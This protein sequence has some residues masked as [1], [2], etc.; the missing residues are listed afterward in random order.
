MVIN[1]ANLRAAQV[2]F[3]ALFL[4]TLTAQTNVHE[5]LAMVVQS[6]SPEETYSWLK[7][8]PRL[9]EWVGPRVIH[10]LE[11][12]GFTIRK[13]DWEATI[14]V[15]RDEVQFDK[16]NLVRPRIMELARSGAAHYIELLVELLAGG[17]ATSCWDGQ[18]FFDTDH[19]VGGVGNYPVRSV[20]NKGTAALAPDA[21]GAALAAVMQFTDDA[22]KPLAIRPTHLVH[23]PVNASMAKRILTAELIEGESNIHRGTTEALLLPELGSSTAWF[24]MDLSRPLKPLILQIVKGVELVAQDQ[25]NDE[26]VF[27]RKEFRYGVDCQDN[28]GYG[29]WQL[30]YGSTGAGS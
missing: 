19:P 15:T 1:A 11:A 26:N 5:K 3:K 27:M 14:A 18:Y 22:G 10:G 23:G 29:L 24:L 7:A 16:L 2:A 6:A 9:R 30:A 20:S 25:P 13:K 28:A 8:L 12:A 21:Y 4:E 17:F